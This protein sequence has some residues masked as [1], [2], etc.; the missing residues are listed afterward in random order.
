MQYLIYYLITINLIGLITMYIDK[1]KAIKN[2]WRI[3]ESILFIIAL[4]GGSLGS[5]I[6][7]K[8]FRHKTKKAK[9]TIGIPLIIIVQIIIINYIF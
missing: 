3:K 8:V 2:K 9:F 7:M 1:K 5:I 4:I 6:G